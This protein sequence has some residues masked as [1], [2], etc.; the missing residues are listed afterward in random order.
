MYL[1]F[2]HFFQ[3]NSYSFPL[4]TSSYHL[5]P[6]PLPHQCNYLQV[7]LDHPLTDDQVVS[8][9]LLTLLVGYHTTSSCLSY[10]TYQLAAN[11]LEQQKLHSEVVNNSVKREVSKYMYCDV[12][13]YTV[14]I[15]HVRFS[16]FC[17]VVACVCVHV[18][19]MLALSVF[20]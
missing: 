20:V 18:L 17:S 6:S 19:C 1:S 12:T 11:P 7:L 14:N 16:I 15:M 4:A 5:P 9:S 8:Y 10:T 3:H 2:V 13:L